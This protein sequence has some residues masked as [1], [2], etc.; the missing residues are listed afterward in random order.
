MKNIGKDDKIDF[1]QGMIKVF[2]RFT[3][4][5]QIF[6]KRAK[7]KIA[8]LQIELAFLAY[9][10]TKLMRAGGLTYSSSVNIFAGDLMKYLNLGL[11][12]K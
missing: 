9:L 3:I 12:L 8:R 2:D 7:S 6:S 1:E 11:M 10:K 5:L 4:I